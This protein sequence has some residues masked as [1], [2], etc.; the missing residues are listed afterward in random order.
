MQALRGT[1]DAN[2]DHLFLRVKIGTV[3]LT[4]KCTSTLIYFH[5]VLVRVLFYVIHAILKDFLIE[6]S[7]EFGNVAE[8]K[9]ERH[10]MLTLICVFV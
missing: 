1:I 3:N 4:L 8:L 6:Y 9:C 5:Y 7:V 10:F 2:K